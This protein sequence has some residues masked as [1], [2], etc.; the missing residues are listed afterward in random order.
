MLDYR[1]RAARRGTVSPGTVAADY[2]ACLLLY[3]E[4]RLKQIGTKAQLYSKSGVICAKIVVLPRPLS[5]FVVYT[6]KGIVSSWIA[7]PFLELA[8]RFNAVIDEFALDSTRAR[9][10]ELNYPDF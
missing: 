3:G 6:T 4:R 9:A 8:V 2:G 5:S 1:H 7:T 10:Y